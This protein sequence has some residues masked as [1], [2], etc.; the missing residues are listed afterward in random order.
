MTAIGARVTTLRRI[1]APGEVGCVGACPL[2]SCA[3]GRAMPPCLAC[4]DELR[5]RL[6]DM[7]LAWYVERAVN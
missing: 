5:A 1:A 3:Q 2:C 6:E 7:Q 4:R